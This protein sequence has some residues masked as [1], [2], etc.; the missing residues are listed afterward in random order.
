M[1]KKTLLSI[2]ILVLLSSMLGCANDDVSIR[3]VSHREEITE[4]SPEE[5]LAA[6]AQAG[7]LVSVYGE[8]MTISRLGKA[9]NWLMINN[10]R[11][12]D[13]TFTIF[14]CAGCEFDL[15]KLNIAAG[16]H[17][18]IKFSVEPEEGQKDIKVKDSNENAYGHATLTVMVK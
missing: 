3:Q 4:K 8:E 13:E 1:V 14:P 2:I 17:A 12:D 10:V 9:E 16:G 11:D 5:V 6:D 7:K 18:I 15:E